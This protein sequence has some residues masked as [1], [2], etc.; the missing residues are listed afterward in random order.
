MAKSKFI[1]QLNAMRHE[2]D[3]YVLQGIELA[4]LAFLVDVYE[5][6]GDK[7]SMKKHKEL[8]TNLN[9]ILERVRDAMRNDGGDMAAAILMKDV[10]E[11]R[12]LKHM[13]D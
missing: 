12:K 1:A 4:S 8:E 9:D 7:I 13:D 3:N 10:E 11:I 2:R 5:V 6:L